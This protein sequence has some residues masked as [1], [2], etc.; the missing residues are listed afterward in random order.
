MKSFLRMTMTISFSLSPLSS[1]SLDFFEKIWT[2]HHDAAK[3]RSYKPSFDVIN[4]GIYQRTLTEG[5]RTIQ[6]TSLFSHLFL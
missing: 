6:L 3:S 5:E 1:L 2:N 4:G